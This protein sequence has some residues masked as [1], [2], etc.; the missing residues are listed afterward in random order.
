MN[1]QSIRLYCT[2]VA[3]PD[4]MF[5]T[6]GKAR[7]QMAVR[8]DD[9][10]TWLVTVRGNRAKATREQFKIGSTIT[11][12]G[13]ADHERRTIVT[14]YVL[15]DKPKPKRRARWEAEDDEDET[16]GLKRFLTF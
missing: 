8:D 4:L 7:C 12:D 9:G 14:G 1:T 16:A 15:L 3:G 6:D 11:L 5:A 2:V 13:A 10:D